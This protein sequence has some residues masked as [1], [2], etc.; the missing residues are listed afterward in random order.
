MIEV[1]GN[2][3]SFRLIVPVEYD[4]G[5]NTYRIENNEMQYAFGILRREFFFSK[6]STHVSSPRNSETGE[7]DDS[8]IIFQNSIQNAS[9]DEVLREMNRINE[10]SYEKIA[11]SLGDKIHLNGRP[12]IQALRVPK[13]DA[14]NRDKDFNVV[15]LDDSGFFEASVEEEPE[16]SLMTMSASTYEKVQQ[17]T[18]AKIEQVLGNCLTYSR[19]QSEGSLDLH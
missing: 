5:R 13:H 14:V 10:E 7:Y 9:F 12:W 4:L 11:E 8:Y 2:N 3:P 16:S 15:H 18:R 1:P 19:E 17:L 6:N